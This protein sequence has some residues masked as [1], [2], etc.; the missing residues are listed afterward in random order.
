MYLFYCSTTKSYAKIFPIRYKMTQATPTV[1][2]VKT[3]LTQFTLLML[4][5]INLERGVAKYN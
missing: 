1:N 4:L 5:L 2:L 3:L